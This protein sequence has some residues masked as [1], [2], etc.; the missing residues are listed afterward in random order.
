MRKDWPVNGQERFDG[1]VSFVAL[2]DSHQAGKVEFYSGCDLVRR[3]IVTTCFQT[4][5]QL[6]LPETSTC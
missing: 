4:L 1:L 6:S 3:N 2:T 5:R